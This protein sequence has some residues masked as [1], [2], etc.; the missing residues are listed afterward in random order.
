[1]TFAPTKLRLKGMRSA[2]TQ[3]FHGTPCLAWLILALWLPGLPP[4]SATDYY[5]RQA[6]DDG[7]QGTS[8][9]GAWRTIDRVNR[10]RFQPGDRI[11]FEAAASFAGNLLLSA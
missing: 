4:L 7:A 5:V 1:M 11:V 3:A 2:R 10:A 6:G 9:N 8:T